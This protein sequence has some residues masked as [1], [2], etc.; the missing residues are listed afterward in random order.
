MAKMVILSPTERKAR[1][2]ITPVFDPMFDAYMASRAELHYGGSDGKQPHKSGSTQQEAHGG[3]GGGKSVG[4][5]SISKEEQEA[6]DE[7]AG[8]AKG[9]AN[10]ERI[11]AENKKIDEQ[12]KLD[13]AVRARD[14]EGVSKAQNKTKGVYGATTSLDDYSPAVQQAFKDIKNKNNEDAPYPMLMVGGEWRDNYTGKKMS[15][16]DEVSKSFLNSNHFEN[17]V[18]GNG[19]V[20]Q[21]TIDYIKMRISIGRN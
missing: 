11:W 21:K 17:A 1:Q 15:W 19:V 14:A 20:D 7:A 13:K 16:S 3:K 5:K 6:L 10:R 9:L 18:Y 12:M 4:K 8:M 2:G